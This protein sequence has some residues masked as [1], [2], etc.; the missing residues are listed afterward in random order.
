MGLTYF[1]FVIISAM[2]ATLLGLCQALV[3]SNHGAVFA[4]DSTRR[5]LVDELSFRRE[6]IIIRVL[7][8]LRVEFVFTI[9]R[10]CRK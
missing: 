10:F 4:I 2:S 3:L 5:Q 7:P 9:A 6:M 1:R 8:E